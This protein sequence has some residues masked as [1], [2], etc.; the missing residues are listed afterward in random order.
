M[1]TLPTRPEAVL[2]DC[3]GL[4]VDSEPWWEAAEIEMFARRGLV[5]TPE[6]RAPLMG[7]TSKEFAD[8]LVERSRGPRE[9]VGGAERRSEL[10]G[11]ESGEY[12]QRDAIAKELLVTV[13]KLIRENALAMPGAVELVRAVAAAGVPMAV[14]SNSPRNIVEAGLAGGRL[15][16]LI[17]EIVSFEDVTRAKPAPDPYLIACERC[18]A[19]PA[20]SVGFED[21]PVGLASVVAAGLFAVAVPSEGVGELAGDLVVPSLADPVL[22][23]WVASWR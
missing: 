11:V 4:L 14:V 20:R 8:H 12:D 9:V 7:K 16:G 5:L 19:T 17:H 2:F 10:R 15:D 23:Q 22:T 18:G 6:E 13:A 3:D 21:S 1:T